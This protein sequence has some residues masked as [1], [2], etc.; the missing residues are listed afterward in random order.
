MADPPP[1]LWGWLW[2]P[3]TGK[4]TPYQQ[5]GGGFAFGGGQTKVMLK[6]KNKKS[7]ILLFNFKKNILSNI[8]LF[9]NK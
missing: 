7:I 4:A 5:V 9:V 6:N 3:P 2:P 1:R 8:L